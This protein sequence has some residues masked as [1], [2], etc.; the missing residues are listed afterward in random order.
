MGVIKAQEKTVERARGNNKRAEAQ[1]AEAALIYDVAATIAAAARNELHQ[2]RAVLTQLQGARHTQ[3]TGHEGPRNKGTQHPSLQEIVDGIQKVHNEGLVIPELGDFVEVSKPNGWGPGG[4]VVFN[5]GAR[6][7]RSE[8]FP[9]D[10]FQHIIDHVDNILH[11]V[12][13]K[14]NDINPVKT[15]W[16]A[17][18]LELA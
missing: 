1:R 18:W 10:D 13:F 14:D 17:G 11:I 4:I 8:A 12:Y 6:A 2:Q 3:R 9:A 7:H 16:F 15:G 5:A